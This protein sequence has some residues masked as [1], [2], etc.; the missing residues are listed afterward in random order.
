MKKRTKEQNLGQ[1]QLL[2]SEQ[3]F[4]TRSNLERESAK[5]VH[6]LFASIWITLELYMHTVDLRQNSKKRKKEKTLRFE[7]LH[8]IQSFQFESPN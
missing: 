4:P 8:K 6:I 3:K 5:F 2:E 1:P 7:L